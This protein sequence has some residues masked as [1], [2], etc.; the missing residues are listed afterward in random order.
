MD[1]NLTCTNTSKHT[2]TFTQRKNQTHTKHIQVLTTQTQTPP[3]PKNVST[4]THTK[5]KHPN[6]TFNPFRNSGDYSGQL[7]MLSVYRVHK[8]LNLHAHTQPGTNSHPPKHTKH[9]CT[10]TQKK[11]NA[12]DTLCFTCQCEFYASAWLFWSAGHFP[13]LQSDREIR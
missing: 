4:Q 9:T 5:H 2:Q 10:K 3:P 1:T 12:T 8:G 11:A 13:T 7:T 6:H